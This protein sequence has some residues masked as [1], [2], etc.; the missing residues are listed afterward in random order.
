M[1]EQLED[2]R[3]QEYER[4]RELGDVEALLARQGHAVTLTTWTGDFLREV[5]AG[6]DALEIDV[7]DLNESQL[8]AFH[9]EL[10]A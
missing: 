9:A 8:A 2:I 10:A 7:D 5:R 1:I 3:R 6:I 4:Q